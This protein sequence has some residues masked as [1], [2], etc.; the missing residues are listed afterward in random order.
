MHFLRFLWCLSYLDVDAILRVL[1]ANSD[2]LLNDGWSAF[3]IVAHT[4]TIIP[5]V[6]MYYFPNPIEIL[7][8]E[9]ILDVEDSGYDS[10]ESDTD[11]PDSDN[12]DSELDY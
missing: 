9:D 6:N 8:E 4:L 11:S 10:S 3:I 5:L 2:I 12:S 7:V 1:Y